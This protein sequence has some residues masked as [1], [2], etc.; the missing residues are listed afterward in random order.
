MTYY[1]KAVLVSTVGI[2][3]VVIGLVFVIMSPLT[4]Y[5]PCT[6]LEKKTVYITDRLIFDESDYRED[7]RGYVVPEYKVQ[8]R[9]VENCISYETDIK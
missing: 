1:E 5:K 7:L 9:E 3:F 2:V 6:I 4:Q 8:E